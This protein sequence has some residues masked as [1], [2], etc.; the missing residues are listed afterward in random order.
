MK[1][2]AFLEFFKTRYDFCQETVT[3]NRYNEG[4][5]GPEALETE[6]ANA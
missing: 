2:S 6:D 4:N 1:I 3:F 5:I